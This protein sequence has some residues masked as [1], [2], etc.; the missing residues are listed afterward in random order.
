[1]F[2]QQATALLSA[3]I[4]FIE[5][6]DNL[7]NTEISAVCNIFDHTTLNTTLNRRCSFYICNWAKK[8]LYGV[9][10]YS[11]A[12]PMCMYECELILLNVNEG[13]NIHNLM[14]LNKLNLGIAF[15]SYI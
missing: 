4:F 14:F 3:L 9:L 7:I 5:R 8:I 6:T 11:W 10:A 15:S 2:D 1:M 13:K 12:A